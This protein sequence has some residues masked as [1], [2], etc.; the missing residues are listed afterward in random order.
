M[1]RQSSFL[2]LAISLFIVGCA[3]LKQEQSLKDINS[4]LAELEQAQSKT[5]ASLEE[6]NNK[7]LLLQEQVTANKNG[8][9]ELKAMAVP[10][11]PP[12]DLKVVKLEGEETKKETA[13]KEEIEKQSSIKKTE[14]L[15][16]PEA[17]YNEA[18]NLFIAGRLSESVDKFSNFILHYPKHRLANNAQYWIGEA[19]YSQRDYQKALLEFKKVVDNYPNE[20]KAP[21]ALLKIGF[22]YL[23]LGSREKALE[24]LKTVMEQYPASEAAAK[25]RAKLQEIQK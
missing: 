1:R 8:V 10:V 11:I 14:Y 18:Q 13:K 3:N 2:A 24:M 17:L 15:P 12:E 25:A 19:Y 4:R 6:V 20:N 16:G 9:E 21:D 7:F 5:N 22:S 23:E